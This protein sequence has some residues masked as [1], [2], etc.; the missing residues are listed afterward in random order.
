MSPQHSNRQQLL[1]GAISCVAELPPA[2][3]TAR[4]I[5]G[6]SGAN[7]ASISYHF[8][9][10]N[11]LVAEATIVVLDRWLAEVDEQL[12]AIDATDP[13]KRIERALHVVN[14]T[15]LE[16]LGSLTTFMQTVSVAASDPEVR[17]LL[18]DGFARTRPVLAA[19]LGLG[20]DRGGQDAAALLLS[21]FHGL[22][23]QATLGDA[24]ALDD[25]RMGEALRR[26]R[27]VLPR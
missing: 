13:A 9:T 19:V 5:A 6:R 27:D 14:A 24:L 21:M 11:R 26:L 2:Q 7:L 17:E 18:V 1:E 20:D 23:I 16:H 25:D 12:G 22:M 8:G 4:E 3:I 10:K 15:R